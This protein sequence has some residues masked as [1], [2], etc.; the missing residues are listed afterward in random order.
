MY[1]FT[2]YWLFPVPLRGGDACVGPVGPPAYAGLHYARGTHIHMARTCRH[3]HPRTAGARAP[4]MHGGKSG[5]VSRG[6]ECPLRKWSYG[7]QKQGCERRFTFSGVLV[8]LNEK[9]THDPYHRACGEIIRVV[10]VSKGSNG[11]TDLHRPIKTSL[12]RHS[13]VQYLRGILP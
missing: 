6:G 2:K 4:C 11:R 3:R 7:G 9:V 1:S 12:N 13:I 5:P 8:I 10:V